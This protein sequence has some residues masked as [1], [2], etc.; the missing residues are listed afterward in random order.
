MQ[1]FKIFMQ[2]SLVL[3]CCTLHASSGIWTSPIQ[4]APPPKQRLALSQPPLMVKK[5]LLPGQMLRR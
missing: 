5:P 1:M 3:S 2:V 4:I